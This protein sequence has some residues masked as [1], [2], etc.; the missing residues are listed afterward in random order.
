LPFKCQPKPIFTYP[1]LNA[2][3]RLF[4]DANVRKSAPNL[5]FLGI[6]L[7]EKEEANKGISY[8]FKLEMEKTKPGRL[9]MISFG[10]RI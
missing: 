6:I 2:L 5:S 8:L 1:A 3:L 7:E 9:K 4:N 10:K